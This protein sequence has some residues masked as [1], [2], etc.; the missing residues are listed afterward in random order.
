[1]PILQQV[2]TIPPGILI[3]ISENILISSVITVLLLP[4]LGGTESLSE[5]DNLADDTHLYFGLGCRNVTKLYFPAGYDLIPILESFKKYRYIFRPSTGIIT[6][7][8]TSWPCSYSTTNT[9]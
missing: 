1:M 8:I 5:L 3:I 2:V 9:T 4:L 6:T 7:T